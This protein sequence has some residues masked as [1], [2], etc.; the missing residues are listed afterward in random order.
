MYLFFLL[1]ISP[2][3]LATLLMICFFHKLH[4][5]HSVKCT[6]KTPCPMQGYSCAF[7]RAGD[8]E[9]VCVSSQE[10][11]VSQLW[12]YE[13]ATQSPTETKGQQRTPPVVRTNDPPE[14]SSSCT[15]TPRPDI[16]FHSQPAKISDAPLQSESEPSVD[17]KLAADAPD[18]FRS[19]STLSDMPFSPDSVNPKSA[20]VLEPPHEN[21]M[22]NM[23][24]LPSEVATESL[25]A[26]SANTGETY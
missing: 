1:L 24:T 21:T 20:T 15:L 4:A 8:S 7:R 6:K 26:T 9:G 25:E 14:T 19:E 22:N 16:L 23:R 13:M 5:D 3:F 17:P 11:G 12:P 10:N 2:K 18:Q